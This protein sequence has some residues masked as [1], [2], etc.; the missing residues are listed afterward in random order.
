[1]EIPTNYSMSNNLNLSQDTSGFNL[2]EEKQVKAL[3]EIYNIVIPTVCVFGFVGNILNVF[4]FSWKRHQRIMDEIERCTTTCLVALALSDMM[5]CLCAFPSAFMSDNC[6][7]RSQFMLYYNAL[8]VGVV[9]F[10]ILTS[11]MLTVITAIMRY[12]A[13]CHPFQS[14]RFVSMKTTISSLIIVCLLALIVSLPKLW[15]YRME[16]GDCDQGHVVLHHVNHLLDSKMFENAYRLIWAI[17]GNFIPLAVLLYCNVRLIVAL[18]QS[19]QLRIYHSRDYDTYSA[20]HR[21]ITITLVTIIIFF[22]M[23]V[24]PS[25]ISKF[26]LQMQAGPGKNYTFQK[27]SLITNMLQSINFSVNFILYYV[28]IAPFRRALHEFCCFKKR[29]S[30]TSKNSKN[31]CS[32]KTSKQH[33]V[34]LMSVRENGMVASQAT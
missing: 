22:L 20:A 19:K 25:E 27:V 33:T 21:R 11:T 32:T 6:F 23:L 15:R 12:L 26:V 5:F 8:S 28:I 10:F 17:V 24:A 14:S 30:N 13:I 34:L 1:M 4:V 18:R 16:Q 7:S 9:D 29:D 31:Y 2:M 3:R